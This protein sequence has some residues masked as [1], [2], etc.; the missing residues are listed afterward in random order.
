VSFGPG[1]AHDPG[2]SG[3]DFLDEA[4]YAATRQ[5]VNRA[6]TLRPDA[7]RAPRF[8]GLEQERVF[9]T[10]WVAVADIERLRHPGD[11][12][13]VRVAGRPLLLTR[14]QDGRLRAF[15]NMCRHRGAQLVAEE[16]RLK[17][18]RCPYHSWTYGLD[19]RL[20]GAPLFEGS[21]IP[22]DQQ[23]LF[24]MDHVVDFDKTDFGLLPVRVDAWGHLVFV[25][26]DDHAM[27]L[28]DWLGDLPQRLAGY[29]LSELSVVARN[30]YDVAANW[31]L[32]AENFMEYYHLPWVHPELAKISRIEDH[33]RFQGPGMYT[34]MTTSPITQDEHSGWSSLEPAAGLSDE[35]AVS[36]RFVWVMPNV[37]LA[38][39]PSH[40]FTIVLEPMA[41]D[42]TIEHTSLAVRHGHDGDVEVAT[43]L[44]KLMSFWDHVNREDIDVVE[45]VQLGVADP[46]YPG[47]RMCYRFEE[48]LHRAQNMI[49]DRMVGVERVPAGDGDTSLY[50][51]SPNPAE[52]AA[53]G[54]RQ[55]GDRP[56][57]LDA[58]QRSQL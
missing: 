19:G 29:G 57:Q 15:H 28:A 20:L 21:D 1:H 33:H 25:N 17:R 4:A 3:V 58:R 45:R 43:A 34:G 40:V 49:I 53:N 7:Y 11:T 14:A 9:A 39:L 52:S 46:S 50:D 8:H 12:L 22:N 56:G 32:L 48:P 55:P 38:V 6:W 51:T 47:G 36:G 23:G 26:L 16:C 27:S 5:P 54:N 13:P 10:S 44:N 30:T 35:D 24:D 41:V 42:R 2:D 31:K 37:A 18:V